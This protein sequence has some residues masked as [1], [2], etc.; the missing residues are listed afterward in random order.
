MK[1]KLEIIVTTMYQKD[2]SKYSEM[3]LQTDAIIANQA[4]YTQYQ[5]YNFKNKTVKIISTQTKGVGSN[6]NIGFIHSSGDILLFADDDMFFENDYERI[7]LE[8]F[9]QRSNADGV[10]F[11]VENY[12]K[13]YKINKKAV[14]K[15]VTHG[16]I[17]G[18]AIKREFLLK[19]NIWFS[20]LFG[21]G[22]RYSC[23][24][25]TLFLKTLFDNKAKIY[26]N[27]KKIAVLNQNVSSWFC[28]YT[29]KFF[30]DKG[31]L[32][33]MLN[34]K[35]AKVFSAY[36]ILKHREKYKEYGVIMAIRQ[37]FKGVNDYK[38]LK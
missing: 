17:C 11:N 6:R 32:Y 13:Q 21:G 19:N 12:T 2:M 18:L 10:V 3:N 1:M 29:D 24:E 36:H 7:I 31:I 8:S 34:K 30:Y 38:A 16:G 27:T 26:I 15:D 28:G 33:F 23:G 4:D 25:D 35:L 22:A 9:K 37:M 14:F 20:L 5:E